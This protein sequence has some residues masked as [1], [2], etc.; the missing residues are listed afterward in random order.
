MTLALIAGVV[1][2]VACVAVI[3]GILTAPIEPEE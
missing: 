3:F 1:L 2:L